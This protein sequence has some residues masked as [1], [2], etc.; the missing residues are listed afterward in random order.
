MP[1]SP[2]VPGWPVLTIEVTGDGFTVAG[3]PV[4]V[5][6]GESPR[7]AAIAM[8]ARTAQSLGRPVRAEAIEAD[9][10][11]FP[12][13][14]SPDGEVGEAAPPIPPAKSRRVLKRRKPAEPAHDPRPLPT[15]A[16]APAAA[17]MAESYAASEPYPAP[18]AYDP[19][20]PVAGVAAHDVDGLDVGGPAAGIPEAVTPQVESP[21]AESP[22]VES[23]AAESPAVERPAV[24]RPAAAAPSIPSPRDAATPTPT[25]D[26]QASLRTI[27]AALD[28]NNPALAMELADVFARETATQGDPSATLAAREVHAYAA[29]RAGSTEQAVTLFAQAAMARVEQETDVARADT[30]DRWAWRLVQNAHYCW[31]QVQDTEEAYGLSPFVLGA[32][33]A[34]GAPDA[35]AA[36][37][38]R[39]HQ[40][41]LRRRLLAS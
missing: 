35:E 17:P 38:A 5:A 20:L 37:A 24:E 32:Y 12:L 8:V 26:Q 36:L 15:P 6:P 21:A 3:E 9:G 22:A 11:V 19:G 29:L 10:T 13:V 1:E 23:S 40:E 18:E 16:P 34:V 4:E 41:Q 28:V 2:V 31:L 7:E 14:V 25:R 33:S 27:R 39:A 30:P